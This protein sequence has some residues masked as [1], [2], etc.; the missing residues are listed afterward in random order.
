MKIENVVDVTAFIVEK[1]FHTLE[2]NMEAVKQKDAAL[3]LKL[4]ENCCRIKK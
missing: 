1:M 3:L 2:D 4:V